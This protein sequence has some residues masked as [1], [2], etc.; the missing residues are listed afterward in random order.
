[1]AQ[2]VVAFN[3]LPSEVQAKLIDL[4]TTGADNFAFI[5]RSSKFYWA[6]TVAGIVWCAYLF[7]STENYLWE[8]WMYALFAAGSL[9]LVSG[10]LF[11]IY[12]I[13]ASRFAKLKDGY[14]FTRDE[15]I[16]TKGKRVEF[17]SL[18]ELEGF[19]YREDIKTIEVWIGERVEKIKAENADDAQALGEAFVQWRNDA[20]ESFLQ[21]YAKPETAYNNSLKMAAISGGLLILLGISFG[22]SYAAKMMNSNYDD[23]RTWSRLENGTTVAEF[24]EYKQRHP[25]GIFAPEAD[26]KIAGIF[27]KLKDDYKQKVKPSADENAVNALAEVL[28]TAGKIPNRTIYVRIKESRRLEESVVKRLR[29]ATGLSISNYDTSIPPSEEAFRKDKLLKDLSLIFLPATRSASMNFEMT[30]NPPA[31]STTFDVNY[32]AR[33]IENYYRFLWSSNGSMTTFYNPAASFEFD[34]SLKS[35]DGRELYKTNFIS[36]AATLGGGNYFDM[37]DAVNYSFDKIYFSA[38]SGDFTKYLSRQF[39]FSE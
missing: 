6:A 27:G 23:R 25:N 30:D 24:E 9:I 35:A 13:A 19:D 22:V 20:R 29:E 26:R 14:V 3:K 1:M 7:A 12:K 37:R 8:G 28:E 31:G 15:L 39:G 32:T 36:S 21:A 17:W 38:V 34:L 18:K 11:A 2:N 16:K 33:S 10:A 5:P 4:Q